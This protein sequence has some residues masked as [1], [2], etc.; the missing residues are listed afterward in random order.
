MFGKMAAESVLMQFGY[1]V[2]QANNLP[3]KQRRK[4]LAAIVDYKVLTKSE[5]ISYLDSFIN[6]R[7]R[8][9]NSDGTLRYAYA[10]SCWQ[11]DRNWLQE[12][13]KN[14]FKEVNVKSIITNK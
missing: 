11:E 10:I 2:S 6:T 4:I 8:Q 7:K 5:V 1:S 13:N 3:V 12:Y 9:R 14:T